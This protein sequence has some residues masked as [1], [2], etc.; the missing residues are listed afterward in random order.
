VTEAPG[1]SAS[2]VRGAVAALCLIQFIDVLGVTVVVTALPQMLADVDG[3]AG[4]GALI[5]TGYALFFGGLLMFGARLGDRTGHR[6]AILTGIGLFAAGALLAALAPT[7]LVL[8]VARCVQ[9]A[10]AAV[11]VPSALRL[12]TT[13]TAEGAAR[14]KAVAAWSA[15]GAAAGA[16]GFV[17][18]G[19]V[20]G[21]A[22]WRA[23][24]WGLL[25][26]AALQAA[27]V[28]FLVPA[29]RP[30]T[31][32]TP[33]NAAGSVLLTAA[34]M[35]VVVGATLLGEQRHRTAGAALLAAA[36]VV[37]G[38][39]VELD[40]RSSA[41]LLPRSLLRSPLLVR[42]A[43]GSFVNT[44]TTSVAT[45]ITLYL[46]GT[47]GRSPFSAAATLLPLSVAVVAGSAPAARLS[48][49]RA[50]E[51]VTAAGLGLI[52]TGI[53]LPLPAPESAV[54]VSVAMAVAGFGLGLSS[55][56]ATSM[57][58][59]VPESV[60]AAASGLIN[61]S[62][63]VGT[64]IGTALILLTAASTTGAAGTGTGTPVVAWAA[65]AGLALVA[66]VAFARLQPAHRNPELV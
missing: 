14:A 57:G 42:G 19:V 2:V 24:F 56:A 58:T 41:P 34:V 15:A 18:G 21:T 1:L 8:T 37:G 46:Q 43:A 16:S 9:G 51:R 36:V 63:Q 13:V 17:V 50:R 39:F 45:L 7:A 38:V 22:G 32:R 30:G 12:L 35:L 44:A 48:V 61:T 55:V 3:L 49:R 54:L 28:L 65:P 52:A 11:A 59:D 23:I 27:A 4:D 26:V 20:T 5:A 25:A 33:L 66:A 40:R 62:A 31:E 64:A 53:A 60:C 10:A 29:D 47:L 6:R